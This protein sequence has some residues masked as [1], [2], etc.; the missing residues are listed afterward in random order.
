MVRALPSAVLREVALDPLGPERIGGDVHGDAQVVAGE[1][2][3]LDAVLVLLLQQPDVKEAHVLEGHGVARGAVVQDHAILGVAL[4]L[5]P[6]AHDLLDLLL[7]RHARGDVHF[8]LVL[9]AQHLLHL[10]VRVRRR[11]DL[12]EHGVERHDLLR[13]GGVPHRARVLEA[14][15]LAVILQALVVL[16]AQLEELP[17]LT[18]GGAVGVGRVRVRRVVLL[19]GQELLRSP[20]LELADGCAVG[21]C[22]REEILRDVDLALVV[23]ANLRDDLRLPVGEGVQ[24][25]D[26]RG[27][28]VLD[29]GPRPLRRRLRHGCCARLLRGLSPWCHPGG[30]SSSGHWKIA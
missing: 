29:V 1:A 17:V 8:P 23:A 10:P 25:A 24:G 12:D 3:G 5:L 22:Q 18:V 9:V 27:P 14:D 16:D 11:A 15:G 7:G 30:R 28:R 4:A 13:R 2:D 21:L 20:L 26:V 19:W 6:E